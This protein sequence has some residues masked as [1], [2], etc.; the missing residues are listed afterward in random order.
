MAANLREIKFMLLGIAV[1]LIGL[2]L[3]SPNFFAWCGAGFGAILTLAVFLAGW[4]ISHKARKKRAA[5]AARP[6]AGYFPFQ[7]N[8]PAA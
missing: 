2:A 4:A 5:F 7:E 1:I 3:S 8:S 6:A